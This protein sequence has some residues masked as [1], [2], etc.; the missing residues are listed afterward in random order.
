MRRRS[1]GSMIFCDL[2]FD[3][4]VYSDFARLYNTSSNVESANVPLAIQEG[5]IQ[6]LKN[7]GYEKFNSMSPQEAEEWLQSST[8][9]AG[10][11]FRQFLNRHG[12]RC[13]KEASIFIN[14]KKLNRN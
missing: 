14:F 9:L 5:A 3:N 6:I 4:D 8:T 7:I 13:L 1:C 10:Y 2:G 12:H 11:K